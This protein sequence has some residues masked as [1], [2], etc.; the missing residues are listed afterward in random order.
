MVMVMVRVMAMVM[1]M[2][3]V[4]VVVVVVVMVIVMVMLMVMVMAVVMV[5][6]GLELK[7]HKAVGNADDCHGLARRR[8]FSNHPLLC[9]STCAADGEL[10][11]AP[12]WGAARLPLVGAAVV[13]A[14]VVM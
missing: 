4:V 9:R 10:R 1:A 6:V 3:M 14:F 12:P 8:G 13:G 5:M 2:V 7:R 11:R